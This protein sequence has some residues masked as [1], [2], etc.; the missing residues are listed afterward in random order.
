[1]NL[2]NYIKLA[3]ML[4]VVEFG[5]TQIQSQTAQPTPAI[6]SLELG[7]TSQRELKNGEIHL[8]QIEVHTGDF[9][10]GTV[11]PQG[12]AI[13]V[14]GYFPDGTKIRSF[15]GPGPGAK[16][17]RFV[18]EAPGIYRLEI[19]AN[20]AKAAGTYRIRLEQIQPFS[21]RLKIRQEESYQSPRL[22]ALRREL[23]PAIGKRW[24]SFGDRS[25]KKVR[26]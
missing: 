26:R 12:F 13:N 25:R 17:F 2:S 1:M 18:G 4:I 14:K 15:G 24:I 7:Q 16:R 21:E 9:V 22:Q 20:E 23:L 6:T 8:Y 5:C 10:R 19:K 11:E 3:L